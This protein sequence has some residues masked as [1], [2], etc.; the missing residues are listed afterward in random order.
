MKTASRLSNSHTE[1]NTEDSYNIIISLRHLVETY[2]Y[3]TILEELLDVS[4]KEFCW[5]KK[6]LLTTLQ[7]HFRYHSAYRSWLNDRK[8]TSMHSKFPACWPLSRAKS[9]HLHRLRHI[10]CLFHKE[11]N[12]W[13]ATATR[14]SLQQSSAV[15]YYWLGQGFTWKHGYSFWL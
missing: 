10:I 7:V 15:S 12:A 9:H 2:I 11:E 8:S 5:K 14:G 3:E 4:T 6:C 13:E 1:Y